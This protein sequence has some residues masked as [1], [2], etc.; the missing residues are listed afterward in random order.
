M[1]FKDI[2]PIQHKSLFANALKPC[3][4]ALTELLVAIE[5]MVN[6]L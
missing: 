1:N 6:N 5:E 4:Q 2:Q 3:Q